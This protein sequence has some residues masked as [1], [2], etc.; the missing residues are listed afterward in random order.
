M[1]RLSLD[2]MKGVKEV[3]YR[4]KETGEIYDSI[5]DA[6]LAYCDRHNCFWGECELA[7][8]KW[9]EKNEEEAARIIGC[10]AIENESNNTTMQ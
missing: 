6:G 7:C 8:G 9:I 5:K 2:Q 3:R 4:N 10:E 1:G